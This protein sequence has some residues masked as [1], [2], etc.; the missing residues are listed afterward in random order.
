[1]SD[2]NNLC[3]AHSPEIDRWCLSSVL[4]NVITISASTLPEEIYPYKLVYTFVFNDAEVQKT[5]YPELLNPKTRFQLPVTEKVYIDDGNNYFSHHRRVS[6][7]SDA[8]KA[9]NMKK[10]AQRFALDFTKIDSGDGP[11]IFVMFILGF[12]LTINAL[13]LEAIFEPPY[14]VHVMVWIIGTIAGS[15]YLV[16]VLKAFMIALQFKYKAEEAKLE[17]DDSEN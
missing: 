6:L 17:D 3:S 16:R 14:W 15:I 9:L 8:A 10:L 11:A 1:M 7:N 2:T 12:A 4:I 5:I 13:I